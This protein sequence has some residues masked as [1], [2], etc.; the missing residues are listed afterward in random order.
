MRRKIII[1]DPIHNV[2]SFG[3]DDSLRKVLKAVIDTEEFQRLRRISQLGLASYVFPGATHTRF[4][5]SLGVAFLALSV[6][7]HLIELEE[8]NERLCSKIKKYRTSVILSALLHDLGHGPFSHSF[9]KVLKNLPNAKKFAPLHEDWSADLI[10]NRKSSICRGISECGLDPNLIASPFD[11][12]SEVEYPLYLRQAISSQ[13]DVDR[14]DY[15]LRDS[16]FSGVTSGTFDI[17]YLISSLAIVQH[18][19][20]KVQTLGLSKKGIKVYENYVLA[21]HQMNRSVYFHPRVKVLEFMIEEFIRLSIQNFKVLNRV[22]SLNR[23]LP[24]YFRSVSEA[25][26][27]N[28]ASINKRDFI[29]QNRA[30]YLKLTESEVWTLV[31]AVNSCPDER[32]PHRM[33]DLASR[34]LSRKPLEHDVIQ[35]GKESLLHDLLQNKGYVDGEDFCIVQLGSTMYK[36]SKDKVFVTPIDD[37]PA[38]EITSHSE[39]ISAFRDREDA[40]NLLILI[41]PKKRKLFDVAKELQAIPDDDRESF[42]NAS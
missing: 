41:D 20:N 11:E 39:I 35:L 4:S 18:G 25:M 10:K 29:S 2:M 40:E 19:S 6:I 3:S 42:K 33:I 7:D 14:M 12:K 32:L 16:H 26:N 23:L 24:E 5:H 31:S 8:N 17:H 28:G 30:H 22:S 34:I 21:R 36:K 9:E 27:E 1:N 15:L 13:L 38:L 37:G